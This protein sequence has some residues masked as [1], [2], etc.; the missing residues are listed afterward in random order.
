MIFDDPRKTHPFFF[1]FS[2]YFNNMS[3]KILNIAEFNPFMKETMKI[4]EIV[5]SIRGCPE[6]VGQ[7]AKESL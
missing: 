6:A 3:R 5:I 7:G 1:I 4:K 2:C